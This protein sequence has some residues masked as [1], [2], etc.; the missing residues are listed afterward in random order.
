[1]TIIT[2][3]VFV[4]IALDA[5]K[6]G[7]SPESAIITSPIDYRG[8]SMAK[9]YCFI[10]EHQINI[11]VPDNINEMAADQLLGSLE[12]MRAEH[13][14]KELKMMDTI[15]S[16]RM[17]AAPKE[18]QVVDDT[19]LRQPKVSK[20]GDAAD[21]EIVHDDQPLAPGAHDLEIPF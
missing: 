1:M 18:G 12:V 11:T 4:F 21:A 19:D 3:K 2:R 15:S 14:Q 7:S 5:V 10:S 17:L 16:L 6:G 9:D 8:F 20:F 13:H